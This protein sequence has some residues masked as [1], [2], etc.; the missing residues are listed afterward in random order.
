MLP[1]PAIRIRRRPLAAATRLCCSR[2]LGGGGFGRL[3]FFVKRCHLLRFRLAAGF[4]FLFFI[5]CSGLADATGCITIFL[6]VAEL[7]LNAAV[8]QVATG[9]AV[10]LLAGACYIDLLRFRLPA[11]CCEKEKK[12]QQ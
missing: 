3:G 10:V 1:A 6:R 5:R 7:N 4:L 11:S 2:A 9:A 8:L 12:Q